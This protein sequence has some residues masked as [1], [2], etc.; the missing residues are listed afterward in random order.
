MAQHLDSAQLR[1]ALRQHPGLIP[2][3]LDIQRQQVRWVDLERFHSYEGFFHKALLTFAALQRMD[4]QASG[5]V[6]FTSD[7]DALRTAP[8]L[9][10]AI[11]PTGFI[12]HM[13]RCGSTL[14]TKVLARS[15]HHLVFGEAAPHNQIWSLLRPARQDSCV[16]SEENGQLYRHLIL[17]M[18]RKRLAT[19]NAHFIKFTSYNILCYDFI[20]RVFPDV[21]ALFLLREPDAVLAS[22][23]QRPPGWLQPVGEGGG[24]GMAGW[25][26][27]DLQARA[28]LSPPEQALIHF[29]SAALQAGAKGLHY[30][31]YEQLTASNLPT[32]LSYFRL[33]LPAEQLLPMQ[34][35]FNYDAKCE[36]SRSPFV[37]DKAAKA[38]TTAPV[39]A[40][41][42]ADELRSLYTQLA[43]S[44]L[45]I[46]P[47]VK[48]TRENSV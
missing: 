44:A 48:G 22:Y 4:K 15:R 9:N 11:Y 34:A 27:S 46:I 33:H 28:Q 8:E 21:P 5:S 14:L 6:S 1:Q 18:G 13:G 17:A 47:A 23:R 26:R 45:N 35:Q 31:N 43:Q 16:W 42:E 32:I 10:D 36:R 29:L 39:L 37:T 41:G 38:Q 19:H 7:L 25:P 2:V 3:E 12:F 24:T 30:L 40:A 20:R